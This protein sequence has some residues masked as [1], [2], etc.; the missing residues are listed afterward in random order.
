MFTIGIL[1][2]QGILCK[3]NISQEDGLAEPG[4]PS[5]YLVRAWYPDNYLMNGAYEIHFAVRDG[6]SFETLERLAGI[7]S[8]AVI[9]PNR[10]RGI[11]AGPCKWEL[12]PIDEEI[13]SADL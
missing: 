3:W 6:A 11:V 13:K 8:F 2:A 10:A 7:L 5:R 1:N 4:P 9:G 12:L